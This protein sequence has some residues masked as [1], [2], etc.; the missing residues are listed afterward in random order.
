[1]SEQLRGL[2]ERHVALGTIPGAVSLVARDLRGEEP[3]EVD[4]VGAMSIAGPEMRPDAIMRIQSMTK[5][6]TAVATLLLVQ[7]GRL[8]LDDPVARWLPE[9]HDRRV[10]RT[11]GSAL[12]DTVPAHRPIVVRDLLL[13]ASGYG[14]VF[15]DVPLAVAMREAGL[16]ATAEPV[17]I[18]ADEWLELLAELP[19]AHQPGEGFRY[20]HSFGLLGILLSRLDGRGLQRHLEEA[21]FEPLG[22]PDTSFWVSEPKLS[23]LPAAYRHEARGA[24]TT[25]VETEPLG[26]GPYAGPPPFDP[27]HAELVSTAAD[28]HRFLSMLV[29]EGRIEGR[30]GS[31]ETPFLAPEL[32]AAMTS[33]Q[34]SP[35]AKTPDSFFP[36][37]W[38][39]MGWG[40]GV[41]VHT[42][43]ERASRYGWSGG[44]GTDFFVDPLDGTIAVLLTQVELG[45]R[46]WPLLEEF[47]QI[48]W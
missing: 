20:H 3:V 19:L 13:N 11:P 37:F 34:V 9:L 7:E 16:E 26:G 29:H 39:G 41:A 24:D 23:R 5:P 46:M 31:G 2:L 28:L 12:D 6:I 35:S 4:A 43:G 17:S 47:Q 36:G 22:M 44:Q 14:I 1:M 40:Y 32:V 33:D 48:V 45:D 15:G 38:D 8:S 10:L 21:V 27:S 30:G 25:L 42:E 18:G